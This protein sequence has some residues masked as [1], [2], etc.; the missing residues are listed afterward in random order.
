MDPVVT[1]GIVAWLDVR[2]DPIEIIPWAAEA[3]GPLQHTL[4][5]RP[6]NARDSRFG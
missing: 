6:D 3:V 5:R 1:A 4:R 2:G